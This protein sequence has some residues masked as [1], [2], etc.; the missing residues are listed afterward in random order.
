MSDTENDIYISYETAL[1][2]WV[3]DASTFVMAAGLIGLGVY[4][5]STAMQWTGAIV[6]FLTTIAT[7]ALD[8]KRQTP[9]Q[10]ADFLYKKFGV[11]AEAA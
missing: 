11:K 8:K 5:E 6:F 9:Q 1:Y 10:A 7:A 4:L 3:H 2:S